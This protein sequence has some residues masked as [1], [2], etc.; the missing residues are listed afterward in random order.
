MFLMNDNKSSLLVY[1]ETI[2]FPVGIY[3]LKVNF[4]NTRHWCEIFPKLTKR[5]II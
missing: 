1:S 4:K 3:L 2:L 5:D